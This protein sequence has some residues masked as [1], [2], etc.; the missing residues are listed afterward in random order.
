MITRR[1]Y[2][3]MAELFHDVPECCADDAI[4]DIALRMMRLFQED[5]PNFNR[6]KFLKAAKLTWVV[7]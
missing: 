7:E 6:E 2:E 5:N 4:R 1:M 3:K